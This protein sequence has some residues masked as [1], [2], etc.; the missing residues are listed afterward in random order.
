MFQ[1]QGYNATIQGGVFTKDN[2]YTTSIEPLVYSHKFGGMYAQGRCTVQ[3]GYTFTT[4]NAKTMRT[5]STYGT[6]HFGYRF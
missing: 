2:P 5:N 4:K 6:I 3:L 1:W